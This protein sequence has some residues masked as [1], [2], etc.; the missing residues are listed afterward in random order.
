MPRANKGYTLQRQPNGIWWVVWH[1]KGHR[2]SVSTRQT[3][4]AAAYQFLAGFL[5]EDPAESRPPLTVGQALVDYTDEHVLHGDVVDKERIAFAI[6]R[7][8]WFAPLPAEDVVESKVR[9]Y[10]D[11]RRTGKIGRPVGN[12]TIRRELV[13]LRAALNHAVR[14][15][16]IA[17]DRLG[18]WSIPKAPPPKDRVLSLDELRLLSEESRYVTDRGY[19]G[20]FRRVFP[21]RLSR[22]HRFIHIAYWTAARRRSIESLTWFQVDLEAKLIK[23]NP[24]GRAQTKKRRPPVPIFGPLMPTLIRAKEEATTEF[25]LDH[26]GDVRQSFDRLCDRL[27]LRD[28]T[29]HTLRH[30]WAVHRAREG[31]DL[32]AIAGVLGDSI[33]TVYRNY[34]HHCPDHLRSA[35]DGR[36]QRSLIT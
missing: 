4:Q 25:V 26:P 33:Q 23:L 14:Q 29:P 28:V 6:A 5:A 27:E 24:T 34:L 30:S 22:L 8:Q 9:A 35:L 7:L 20:R 15:R 13:T 2:K 3:D 1:E 18:W 36:N 12:G 16:R 19:D 17:A 21:D 11:G 32:F 31:G 10:I